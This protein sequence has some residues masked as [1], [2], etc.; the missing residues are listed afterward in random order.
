MKLAIQTNTVTSSGVK[1][2]A[3]FGLEFN[4]KIARMLSE[5]IYS[6][7]ILAVVRE[8]LCNAFDAHTMV[9]KPDPVK[10][11][12]PNALA[13]YWAVRD[14]GPGLSQE[15][16]MG[17]PENPR[18]LFN[19]YG[20]SGK[21]DSNLAIGGF[22]VGSKAGFAY[23][24][25]GSAF[26]VTSWHKGVKKVYTAHMD[27]NG[28][29]NIALMAEIA[30]IEPTGIE[31]K[32]PVDTKDMGAFINKTKQV[33]Q[34]VPVRPTFNGAEIKFEDY[35]V[36]LAGN[37]WRVHEYL[38]TYI[39][40]SIVMGG[41]CYYIDRNHFTG[42]ASALLR[43][44]VQFDVPIG[45]VELSI[46]RESLNYD[47]GTIAYITERCE[48]AIEEFKASL[49]ARMAT[50]KTLW[51]KSCIRAEASL[52][53]DITQK[54]D[55]KHKGRRSVHASYN[56]PSDCVGLLPV[57]AGAALD[58]IDTKTY[59]GGSRRYSRNVSVAAN[60]YTVVV[61]N[62]GTTSYTSVKLITLVNKYR[63]KWPDKD[64][65]FVVVKAATKRDFMRIRAKMGWPDVWEHLNIQENYKFPGA[66]TT[67]TKRTDLIRSV[68]VIRNSYYDRACF[69][70]IDLDFATT[71]TIYYVPRSAYHIL[72]SFGSVKQCSA[73]NIT[74]YIIQT[75]QEL[76]ADYGEVYAIPAQYENLVKANKNFK[77]AID[78]IIEKSDSVFT[79]AL[80]QEKVNAELGV[81]HRTQSMYSGLHYRLKTKNTEYKATKLHAELEKV[82]IAK[83]D[84]KFKQALYDSVLKIRDFADKPFKDF[85][86]SIKITI[87]L[88]KYPMLEV[89]PSVHG[90]N[91]DQLKIVTDYIKQCEK[92]N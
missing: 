91:S 24:K 29:P 50:A 73:S 82:S 65:N 31:I 3:N 22:G 38:N 44:S 37:G 81:D 59:Y 11:T 45:A 80:L 77:N 27:T 92:G 54:F 10:C 70:G 61:W 51:E 14:F 57:R 8:Y 63:A 83:V 49:K 19:T 43:H 23:C 71:D 88:N 76:Q 53:S 32:I 47:A 89:L 18:G 67:R 4:S 56:V 39:S 69:K 41:I 15:Q 60:P 26:T 1:A 13:P 5:Q 25:Q 36:K 9:G 58:T 68:S 28:I 33:C 16:I 30:S 7:P 48:K 52:L 35:K 62:D 40:P 79:D 12:L 86:P 2:E 72:Q 84:P 75:L 21:D 34:W 46:S 74:G 55:F 90:L 17:T 6:D 66:V 64:I 20:K 87:D 78:F 85:K 42:D